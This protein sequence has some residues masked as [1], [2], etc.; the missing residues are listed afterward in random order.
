MLSGTKSEKI[1]LVLQRVFSLGAPT[2]QSQPA[3]KLPT[4]SP[5]L[6]FLAHYRTVGFSEVR[7][8]T[9]RRYYGAEKILSH[10]QCWAAI[11][12]GQRFIP[13]FM[14]TLL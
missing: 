10:S 2:R 11:R 12:M 9:H 7:R 3:Y 1:I 13:Q 5:K 4:I 6:Q 14:F 8:D